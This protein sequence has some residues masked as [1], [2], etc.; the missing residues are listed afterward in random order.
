MP[1]IKQAVLKVAK[2]NPEFARA[3]TA[4][5]KK[6]AGGFRVPLK[7]GSKVGPR[8]IK[9]VCQKSGE[10]KMDYFDWTKIQWEKSG[11]NPSGL[12]QFKTYHT[13]WRVWPKTGTFGDRK[14]P[15]YI[16]GYIEAGVT[17]ARGDQVEVTATLY[18]KV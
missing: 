9:M 5:L 2:E 8:Q 6:T 13:I 14:D 10:F 7:N 3:L 1:T 17:D 15:G 18:V 11:T 16:W 12:D 4:E